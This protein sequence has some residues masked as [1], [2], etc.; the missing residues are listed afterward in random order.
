MVEHLVRD[1]GVAGSNPA[2]PTN[3]INHFD[4]AANASNRCADRYAGRNPLCARWTQPPARA[5][6]TK[7]RSPATLAARGASKPIGNDPFIDDGTE[8]LNPRFAVVNAAAARPSSL[9]VSCA[10]RADDD[11]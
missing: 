3:R 9:S 11:R 8:T 10:G 7:T 2:T 6:P 4:L 5:S 1:E